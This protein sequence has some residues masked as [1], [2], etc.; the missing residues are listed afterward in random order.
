MYKCTFFICLLLCATFIP[1]QAADDDRKIVVSSASMIWDMVNNIAGDKVESQLIVPIGSDPHL[2]DPSPT[3]AQKVSKA[4][5]IFMNGLTFEGWINQLIESSG[6]KAPTITV[7]NGL[8]PISSSEYQDAFDPHAWMD[9]NKAQTYI[10]N[11]YEG[12]VRILPEEKATFESNYKAYSKKLKELDEYITQQINRV[13][14]EHRIL[15]TSHDAFSYY[16][17]RYGLRIE[18]VMGTSTEAEAQTSDLRRVMSIINTSGVPAIFVE[19][20]VNPKL[21]NQIASDNK[22]KI[23]GSLYADSIGKKG[24]DGDSYYNMMKSNTDVITKA[25]LGSGVA[26]LNAPSEGSGNF[27]MYGIIGAI[28]LISLLFLIFRMNK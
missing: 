3:D 13:P 19:S 28:M 17:Q 23:G 7:T 18:G 2:Y 24:S 16:G 1:I 20:T 14:E 8:T 25:L 12:L 11:I 22:V 6:T 5:L 15:I 4:D 10:K 21:M 27:L 9:V 26:Q